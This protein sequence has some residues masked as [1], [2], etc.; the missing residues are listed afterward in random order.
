MKSRTTIAICTITM[1]LSITTLCVSL[2]RC[3]PITADW[4]GILVGVLSFLVT[5]LL[6]WQIYALFDIRE[7][8]KEVR[9]NKAE[10]TLEAHKR[11]GEA[12]YALWAFYMNSIENREQDRELLLYACFNSGIAAIHRLSLCGDYQTCGLCTKELIGLCRF[13][14]PGENYRKLIQSQIQLLLSV[15][16]QHKVP[17]YAELLSALHKRL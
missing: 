1:L 4:L 2:L 5:V 9:K 11:L 7:I 15:E 3:E 13:L 8:Q 16:N 17:G 6:G 12:H 14:Q 10:M